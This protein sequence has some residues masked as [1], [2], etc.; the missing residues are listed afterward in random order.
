M[1]IP[2]Q[3]GNQTL[4]ISTMIGEPTTFYSTLDVFISG[5]LSLVTAILLYI[6]LLSKLMGEGFSAAF[7]TSSAFMALI[8]FIAFTQGL[9]SILFVQFFGICFI[10]SFY[11]LVSDKK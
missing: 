4:N 10:V 2:L 7:F 8:S 3:V 11:L 6:F 9:V 5:L 1:T